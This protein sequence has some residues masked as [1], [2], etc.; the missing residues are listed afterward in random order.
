[1]RTLTSAE[2]DQLSK[3]IAK[4]PITYIE[5]YNELFDHYAS[6]FEKGD[7]SL[8]DTLA[9][10]DEHFHYQKVNRIDN[11]LLVSSD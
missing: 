4:K 9:Q 7:I 10:L 5:L 3:H 2:K 11:N 6:T 1:M 8:E